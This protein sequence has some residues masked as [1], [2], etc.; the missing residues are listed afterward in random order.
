MF[1]FRV[2]SVEGLRFGV[3]LG[4]RLPPGVPRPLAGTTSPPVRS[5]WHVQKQTSA[6]NYNI[7]KN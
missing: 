5:L 2:G 6:T 7:E 3:C 1:G 4:L